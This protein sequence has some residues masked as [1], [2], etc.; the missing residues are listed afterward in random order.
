MAISS[1]VYDFQSVQAQFLIKDAF[2]RIG[3]IPDNITYQEQQSAIR[4]INLLLSEW[5]N[6]NFN[7]WTISQSMI[8]L[9]PSVKVYSLPKQ[10]LKVIQCE[11]RTSSRNNYG[12]TANASG[13]TNLNL[14]QNAFD[15]NPLTYWQ[16]N[17]QNGYIEYS[18]EIRN[19][20]NPTMITFLGLNA[21]NLNN[22]AWT[23][24][25]EASTDNFV[26]NNITLLGPITQIFPDNQI[27][28]FE[29]TNVIPFTQVRV[30][31]SNNSVIAFREIYLNNNI[32]DI[33]MSEVSQYN[34]IQFPRKNE[35]GR[36]TVYYVNYQLTPQL[37]VWQ[38]PSPQY[39]CI[40]YSAQSYFQTLTAVNQAIDVPSS[41]YLPLILGIAANL[42][43]KYMPEKAEQL[44]A[45]YNEA[46]SE[47]IAK[48]RV[49]LP[50]NLGLYGT[51]S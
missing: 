7:C 50:L 28:W 36:P 30:Q 9:T 24:S 31:A 33:S 38:N 27:I 21:Y 2:E 44:N 5:G 43:Q 48:N 39:N 4:I 25:L 35:L 17:A 51:G 26:S 20:S 19:S 47:A 41:F 32:I 8:G 3:M 11:L 37:Y 14:P 40:Y 13:S 12:G 29:L 22:E 23:I 15:S 1:G 34:Y 46:L 6:K 18:Y 42:A 45:A 16:A 49:N 10:T